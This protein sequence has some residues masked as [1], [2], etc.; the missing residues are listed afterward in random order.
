VARGTAAEVGAVR[1]SA[2]GY[3]YTKTAD[4][5]WRLTHHIVAEEKLGRPLREDERVHF[6]G[7]K[8]D[9]SPGNIKVVE[10]GTGSIRRR[11]AQLEARIAELQGELDEINR[12]INSGPFTQR[13]EPV[14][15]LQV[16]PNLKTT[17]AR[18]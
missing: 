18:Y 3:H 11:K 6:I 17:I 14:P 12:E 1:I 9:L 13:N 4:Q 16:D 7:K 10:K 5:G 2:N 8:T 15:P